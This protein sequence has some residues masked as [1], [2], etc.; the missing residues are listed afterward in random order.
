MPYAL[1]RKLYA[2]VGS[3]SMDTELPASLAAAWGL[4][5]RS[6][7][8]PRP[9]LTLDRIVAAGVHVATTEGLGAVSMGRVAAELGAATMSLYRYVTAKNELL[10]LMVD[11]AVGPPP[12][13]PPGEEWRDGM[14]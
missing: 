8:G 4:R 2:E 14:L 7:K 9:G 6:A 1:L 10:D 12:A 13:A 5:T 3:E 11:A